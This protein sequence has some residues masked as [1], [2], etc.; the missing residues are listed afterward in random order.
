[1]NPEIK[2]DEWPWAKPYV[3]IEGPDE[4]SVKDTAVKL[5]LEWSQAKHGSVE[6][7]YQAEY[8]VSDEDVNH[9]PIYRFEA[10]LSPLFAKRK[11]S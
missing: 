7:V 5:G 4:R 2:L 3:E 9:M 10:A 11:K 6:V 8:D 1:M